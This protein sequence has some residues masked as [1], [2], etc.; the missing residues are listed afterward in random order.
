MP[1]HLQQTQKEKSAFDRAGLIP[2]ARSHVSET[3]G[4]PEISEENDGEK[5]LHVAEVSDKK[6][7]KASDL[8]PSYIRGLEAARQSAATPD[9][10]AKMEVKFTEQYIEKKLQ[11]A[12][13]TS[14][15][16]P[17]ELLN[18]HEYDPEDPNY[19][20]TFEI[21]HN[22]ADVLAAAQNLEDPQEGTI[23]IGNQQYSTDVLLA[24]KDGYQKPSEL[25]ELRAEIDQNIKAIRDSNA[26]PGNKLV[27]IAQELGRDPVRWRSKTTGKCNQLVGE[28]IKQCFG[29]TPWE[30]PTPTCHGL[31]R[32]LGNSS[33][34]KQVWSIGNKDFDTA[35]TDFQKFTP[36]QGDIVIWDNSQRT[37]SGI[38]DEDGF[39]HYAG[40]RQT[41]SGYAKSS[42]QYYTGTPDEPRDF[43]APTVIYRH[44]HADQWTK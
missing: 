27:G 28:A 15:K 2:T 24:S 3:F 37:H 16:A 38:M 25:S 8:H 1:E 39:L 6:A 13:T 36:R 40:S 7:A 4:R 14:G 42:I 19:G 18:Q 43:G 11:E 34:W 31:N 5:I 9:E 30:G 10:A 26:P 20:G 23:R 33:E 41:D 35:L 32:I 29:K 12:A 17:A 21:P 22:A 44:K